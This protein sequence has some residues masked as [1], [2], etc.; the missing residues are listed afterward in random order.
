MNT[1]NYF[2][3]EYRFLS[4]FYPFHLVFWGIHY[5]TIEHAYQAAKSSSSFVKQAIANCQT[6]GKA[7]AYFKD[8]NMEPSHHWNL[9][10][11]LITMEE[12]LRLK[13]SGSEP[14]M[15]QALLK[16]GEAEL[17]EGN[18]HDDTF[19][20]VYN[21]VGENHL[22][23]LLMKIRADLKEEK[24]KI[25]E[26]LLLHEGSKKTTAKE[27]GIDQRQLYEKIVAYEIVHKK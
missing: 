2:Q 14:L 1:I 18:D 23:K 19:W 24:L 7:K 5:S 13:F 22:G 17:I 4:N 11:K 15:L 16:T 10:Y 21:G 12:L 8:Q 27:L 25:E 26:L 9:D 6:P 3:G 20:G